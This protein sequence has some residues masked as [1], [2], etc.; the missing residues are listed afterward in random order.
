MN[1]QKALTGAIL[2]LMILLLW[3]F[4]SR[5]LHYDPLPVIKEDTRPDVPDKMKDPEGLFPAWG[6]EIEQRNLFSKTRSIKAPRPRGTGGRRSTAVKQPVPREKPLEVR[7]DLTLSG[8]I[9]N[10][11]GEYVAFITLNGKE[12]VGIRKGESV[13]EAKV[14]HIDKRNVTLDWRGSDIRLSLSSQPLI[15]R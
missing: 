3:D 7:P 8:I 6:Q 15:K 12:T 1:R 13:G 5:A 4:G 14:T 9:K 11:S 10:Q 2:A